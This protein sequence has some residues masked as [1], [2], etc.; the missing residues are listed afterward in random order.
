MPALSFPPTGYFYYCL[1]RTLDPG[2]KPRPNVEHRMADVCGSGI[3]NQG[4]ISRQHFCSC[5][6]SPEKALVRN[7]RVLTVELSCPSTLSEMT[8][9]KIRQLTCGTISA[10]IAPR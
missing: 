5:W 6:S 9:A 2:A 8:P 10:W 4:S 3:R 1:F 7:L